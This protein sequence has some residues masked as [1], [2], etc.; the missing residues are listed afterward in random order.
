MTSTV[1]LKRQGPSSSWDAAH[2]G[3][4]VSDFAEDCDAVWV[5]L[6]ARERNNIRWESPEHETEIVTCV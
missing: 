3:V 4:R 2:G 5:L 6:E 1:S